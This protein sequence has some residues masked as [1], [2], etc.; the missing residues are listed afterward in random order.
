LGKTKIVKEKF[1]TIKQALLA[2]HL[3]VLNTFAVLK[4]VSNIKD[5]RLYDKRI[6]GLASVQTKDRPKQHV[7]CLFEFVPKELL[8]PSCEGAN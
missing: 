1:V 5:A 2:L 8:V 7:A 4:V 6:S 3:M